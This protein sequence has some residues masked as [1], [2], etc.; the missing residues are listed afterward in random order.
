MTESVRFDRAAEYYDRTRAADPRAMAEVLEQLRAESVGRGRCLEIGVGTGILALAL[1][2]RGIPMVGVDLSAPMLSK[3]L[4]KAGGRAPFPLTLADA[5]SLPFEDGSFGVALGR[6]VLHLIPGWE[7]VVD[8]LV[9]VVRP[10]GVVLLNLGG[11]RR[12]WSIVDRFLDAAGGIPFAVGLDPREPEQLDTAFARHGA[13]V[14]L[15]PPIPSRDETT[16]G[17]FLEEMRTGLHSWTWRVPDE[18]REQA[19]PAVRAWA[20]HEFGSLDEPVEPEVDIGWRAYD[21]PR[22]DGIL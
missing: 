7:Q 14:R 3:L 21:L 20:E 19:V 9:R 12:I 18:V 2:E 6:W 15:L 5:T 8:E 13:E 11:F 22:P 17:E 16:I 10:G 1:A 4:D